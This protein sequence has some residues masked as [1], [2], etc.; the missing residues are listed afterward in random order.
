MFG[1]GLNARFRALH[2]LNLAVVAL[3]IV[4]LSVLLVRVAF[5]PGGHTVL[6]TYE[7]GGANWLRGEKL[8]TDGRG[9]VYSPLAAAFFA[10]FSFLP[11]FLST[12]LWRGLNLSIF[13]GAVF[14]W[15]KAGLHCWIAPRHFGWV[16]LLLLPLSIGNFFNGQVNP[17]VIGL[18]MISILAARS[19][20]WNLA[21]V[22]ITAATY[23]KIYPLAVGLILVLLHPRKLAWRLL[24]TLALFGLAT[25]VLQRPAYVADQYRLWFATRGADDRKHYKMTIAP[26]DLWML[27]RLVHGS[28][29][30]RVY[31]VIQVLSGAAVAGLGLLGR[32]RKWTEER[33]WIALLSLVCAWMLLCGPATESATY[34]LLAPPAVLALVQSFAQPLPR[35]LRGGFVAVLAVLLFALQTNSFWHLKKDVYVMSVQPFGALLF[36]AY[37]LAWV[38]TPAFWPPCVAKINYTP[39][40]AASPK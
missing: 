40:A 19:E 10:P 7:L 11:D 9:F 39:T 25:F 31:T 2:R 27:L 14:W 6:A 20:R 32:W 21:A 17:I 33:I 34:I 16:F 36:T 22:A 35:W 37:V 4:V 15:L 26:R 30:P 23:F 18:S 3:W 24:L 29:S 1:F 5:A 8:Y 13:L 12:V 38:L 28:V